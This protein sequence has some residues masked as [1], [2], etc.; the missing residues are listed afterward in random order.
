MSHGHRE[1]LMKKIIILILIVL[2]AAGGMGG[3][4]AAS[5]AVIAAPDNLSKD[6]VKLVVTWTASEVDGSFVSVTIPFYSG[7]YITHVVTDPGSTAPTDNYDI[8]LT[9]TYGVDVMG[10]EL[11]NRDTSNSEQVVPKIDTVFGSRMVEAQGLTLA[12]TGNI[13][14]SATGT[15]AIYTQR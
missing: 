11:T 12:I 14:N 15:I 8:T 3:A 10:G 6:K 1:E 9:D 2:M 4:F 13:V 5:S 7:S